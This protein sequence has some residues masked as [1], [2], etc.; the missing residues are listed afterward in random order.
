MSDYTVVNLKQV[1]DQAPRFGHSPDLEAR[2]AT[3]PLELQSS[4]ISYQ[5]LAPKFRTPFGHRHH[6]QEELYVILSGSG[7]AKLDDDVVELN[8]WDAVR[9]PPRTMRCFE[10]G[11]DGI[12]ILAIGAPNT[13]PPQSDVVD[14]TPN[15]WAGS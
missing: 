14:M 2:F 3:G 7:R 1:E 11:S 4:G 15:W 5:R 13:G 10:G 12:E 9:V 8:Q 6:R